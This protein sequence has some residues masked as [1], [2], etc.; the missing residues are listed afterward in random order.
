[1]AALNVVALSEDVLASPGNSEPNYIVISVT[2][3]DGK[4]VSKLE[5]PDFTVK[6]VVAPEGG[7]IKQVVRVIESD[8]PGVY[9]MEVVP[10][11]NEVWKGGVY[12]FAVGV[13]K[14]FDRGQTIVDVL[15]D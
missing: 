10:D 11:G 15:M 9:V 5:G 8:F 14:G 4:P 3:S 12:I 13:H 7:I 2:D 1:M 6:S